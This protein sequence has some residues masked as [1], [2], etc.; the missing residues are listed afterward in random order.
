VDHHPSKNFE[1]DENVMQE[2]RRFLDEQKLAYT[3]AELMEVND[4]L[5]S[6][7]KAEIL[8]DVYGQEEGQKVRAEADPQVIKALELL[9]KAK[10]LAENAKR[11]VA[12][13]Q[14]AHSLAR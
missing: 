2:F 13:R 14:S 11:V 7:I 3:E 12:E 10:E 5:R 6:N 4:W 8:V 9:P 1:V